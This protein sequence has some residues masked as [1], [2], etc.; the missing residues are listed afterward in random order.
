MNLSQRGKLR[1]KTLHDRGNT[2][3]L[4]I[5]STANGRLVVD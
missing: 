3:I 2:L 4:D 5:M 1:G